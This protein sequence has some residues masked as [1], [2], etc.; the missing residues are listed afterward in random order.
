MKGEYRRR[1]VASW[2]NKL[3]AFIALLNALL[4]KIFLKLNE[5]ER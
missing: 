2:K 3:N 5:E 1:I 4:S